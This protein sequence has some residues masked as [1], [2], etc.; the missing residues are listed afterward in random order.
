MTPVMQY[1]VLDAVDMLGSLS[2][3]PGEQEKAH[4]LLAEFQ[5]VFSWHDLNLGE[6][7]LVEHIIHMKASAGPPFK[8]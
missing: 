8:E 2:W 5:D 4:L 1:A 6:T 3:A 7:S